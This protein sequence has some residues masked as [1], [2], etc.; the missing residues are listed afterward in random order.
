[1]RKGAAP[2][3][4]VSID[5]AASRTALAAAALELRAVGIALPNVSCVALPSGTSDADAVVALS[6]RV[7]PAVDA[8]LTSTLEGG[9]VLRLLPH[10]LQPGVTYAIAVVAARGA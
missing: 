6:W 3:V 1:M 2:L 9:R 5:G 8:A 4:A 10:A 7:T